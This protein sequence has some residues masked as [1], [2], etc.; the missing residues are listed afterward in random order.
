MARGALET[1]WENRENHIVVI[2]QSCQKYRPG[3]PDFHRA[4]DTLK[5]LEHKVTIKHKLL[6]IVGETGDYPK[7]C[8]GDYIVLYWSGL[9]CRHLVYRVRQRDTLI[10]EWRGPD[11]SHRRGFPSLHW[12]GRITQRMVYGSYPPIHRLLSLHSRTVGWCKVIFPSHDTW[13][14]CSTHANQVSFS[15]KV[16]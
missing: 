16:P 10:V 14:F 1:L 9:R 5:D 13:S 4:L 2:D 3:G 15:I 6:G 8:G 12:P 11:P 7:D